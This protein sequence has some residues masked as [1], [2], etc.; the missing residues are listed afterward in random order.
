MQDLKALFR[1]VPMLESDSKILLQ[2][3][4]FYIHFICHY[5]T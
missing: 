2:N 5:F 4:L 1:L 3:T